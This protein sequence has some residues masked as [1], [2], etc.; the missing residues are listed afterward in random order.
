MYSTACLLAL[1]GRRHMMA[2]ATGQAQPIED[3]QQAGIVVS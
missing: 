1:D 3:E 2:G